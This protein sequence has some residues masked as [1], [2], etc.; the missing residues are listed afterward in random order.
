MKE[1]KQSDT[2][3][4]E[5]GLVSDIDKQQEQQEPLLPTTEG[6]LGWYDP[7]QKPFD[8]PVSNKRPRYFL[9][10]WRPVNISL[11][12][13]F[14][15]VGLIGFASTA[16]SVYLIKDRNASPIQ[17]SCMASVVSL[18]WAFK[19]FIGIFSD[20]Y[21]LGGYRRKPLILFGWI[22]YALSNLEMSRLTID[23]D[24]QPSINTI[25]LYAFIGSFCMIIA[26][27][28]ND[29]LCVERSQFETDVDKGALQSVGYSSRAFGGIIAAVAGAIVYNKEEFGWGLTI[30]QIY[31]I[32]GLIPLIVVVPFVWPLIE[33]ASNTAFESFEDQMLSIWQIVQMRSLWEPMSFVFL[34][35]ILQIPNAAFGNFL[36]LGL[37]FSPLYMGILNITS[38][39]V[40]LVAMIIYQKF[41]FNLGIRQVFIWSTVAGIFISALQVVLILRL[42]LQIGLPDIAFLVILTVLSVAIAT[43]T[44]VPMIVMFVAICPEGSEG[45]TYAM[46]TTISNIASTVA[47]DFGTIFLK[48]W[49][50]SNDAIKRG[51]YEGIEYLT[52]L[53]SAISVIPVAFIWLLPES[54]EKL[55][56]MKKKEE[57]NEIAGALVVIILVISILFTVILNLYILLTP[58]E[59][60]KK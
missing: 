48:I 19:I 60:S 23:P 14:L 40:T 15:T 50:C 22:G 5:V 53:T 27:V 37:E 1:S 12:L 7:K 16:I 34:Y 2:T 45:T 33:I 58:G 57:K 52:I 20:G 44:F 29:A 13:S 25:I 39:V 9:Q 6:G 49:D 21:P 36:L 17:L 59:E 54:K 10:V 3:D 51:D 4:A 47:S 30:S 43:V 42:N 18:P 38:T 56:E 46:L 31:L 41:F 55:I 8:G 26:D 32:E 35:N 28:A 11:A 24:S